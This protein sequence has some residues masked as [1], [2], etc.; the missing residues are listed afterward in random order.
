MNKFAV[1]HGLFLIIHSSISC[2][3]TNYSIKGGLI[4]LHFFVFK[5]LKGCVKTTPAIIF[6]GILPAIWT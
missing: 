3:V 4:G 1:K 6:N 2:K 5:V